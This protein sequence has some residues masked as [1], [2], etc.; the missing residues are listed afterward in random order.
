MPAACASCTGCPA[1]PAAA[2]RPP[3]AAASERARASERRH[4]LRAAPS[5]SPSALPLQVSLSPSPPPLT[6][7]LLFPSPYAPPPP[8]TVL[9]CAATVSVMDSTLRTTRGS[10]L[11]LS[12][13]THLRGGGSRRE[14]PREVCGRGR[15]RAG[16]V[17]KLPATR[18]HATLASA[19]AR[20]QSQP[21]PST[22]SPCLIPSP[23]APPLPPSHATHLR[24][25]AW[26]NPM[27]P[28][29]PGTAALTPA[30]AAPSGPGG[31]AAKTRASGDPSAATASAS[32]LTV[33]LLL[34]MSCASGAVRRARWGGQGA[35]ARGA[36][37]LQRRKQ[38]SAGRRD[39][40]SA[41]PGGD[42]L[43]R[44]QAFDDAD[45]RHV[46]PAIGR[47]KGAR[48]GQAA[49]RRDLAQQRGLDLC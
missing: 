5:P 42:H 34:A 31:T 22:S 49:V 40:H 21:P 23:P 29:S 25:I 28:A 30:S 48:I 36:A 4:S 8:L 41:H 9:I 24:V 35:A 33:Y 39:R 12:V 26:R 46:L 11:L 45:H 20:P 15:R 43:G 32:G 13:A 2:R 14:A 27:S 44:L 17:P 18:R 19:L 38:R 7:P 1:Q 3:A 10:P 6:L 37:G 16:A 47:R